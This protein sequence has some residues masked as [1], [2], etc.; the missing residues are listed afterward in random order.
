MTHPIVDQIRFAR[1]E[2]VRGLEGISEAEAVVRVGPAN[3]IGW[4]IGHLAWQ[5]QRYWLQRPELDEEYCFGCPPST[6]ALAT[7]WNRWLAVTTA[8]DPHLDTITEETLATDPM[9]QGT[10]V[11]TTF[12]S[13]ALRVIYHYWYHLGECMGIRQALGHTG[14]AE[15]V[16]DIDTEAPYRR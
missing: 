15:F 11:G 8:C 6:P 13:M 14:L 10:Q 5:E 4:T 7:S 9:Y 2:F 1:A 12:G 3:S 16:G